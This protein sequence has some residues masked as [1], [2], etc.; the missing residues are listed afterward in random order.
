MLSWKVV[1]WRQASPAQG[2][3][4]VIFARPG[5]FIFKLTATFGDGV[6]RSEQ[7]SVRVDES[8]AHQ[9]SV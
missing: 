9:A 6:K 1:V 3:R 4:E 2:S 5:V 7:V 8:H